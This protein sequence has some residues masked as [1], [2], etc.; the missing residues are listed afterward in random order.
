[1]LVIVIVN[2]NNNNSTLL[3]E[4]LLKHPKSMLLSM[5]MTR[6]LKTSEADAYANVNVNVF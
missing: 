5:S 3:P 2:A 1:M 6:I 4:R